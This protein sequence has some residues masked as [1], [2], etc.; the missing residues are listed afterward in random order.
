MVACDSAVDLFSVWG[1]EMEKQKGGVIQ[2]IR[3]QLISW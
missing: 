3:E 2:F 1:L